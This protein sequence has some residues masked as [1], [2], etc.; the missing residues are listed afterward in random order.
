[1][2]TENKWTVSLS[3]KNVSFGPLSGPSD[4]YVIEGRVWSTTDVP[5]VRS[6]GLFEKGM[7]PPCPN[8]VEIFLRKFSRVK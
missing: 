3:H 8:I 5:S 2:T 4:D 7:T 6:P 1:M